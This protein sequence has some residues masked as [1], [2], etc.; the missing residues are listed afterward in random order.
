MALLKGYL[1]GLG[2]VI[3]LGPVFFYLLK[4]TLEGGFKSGISVALGIVFADFTCVVICLLGA[5][6]FFENTKN[7]FWIG[8]VGGLILLFLGLKFIFKPKIL[9][10]TEEK[11]KLSKANYFSLF[12]QGFLIN[13]INPFVFIV[14]ISIIGIAKVEYG[15]TNELFVFIGAVL[16]GIFST[17]LLKV[18]LAHRIKKFLSPGHLI[19][20]YRVF[21]A[22]LIIFGIWA[23]VYSFNK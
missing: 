6:A 10:Q 5:I 17:D 20:V 22:I 3:F 21:G 14:W 4:C 15:T 16:L 2:F 9:P 1:L 13:F 8:I 7:Q 23:I 19:K 12:T 11:I 18:M